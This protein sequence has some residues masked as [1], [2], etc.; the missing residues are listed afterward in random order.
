MSFV[1]VF[2]GED[3][4]S[5]DPFGAFHRFTAGIRDRCD[6]PPATTVLHP[7]GAYRL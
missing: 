7:I 4:Q 5:L 1:H 2:Q 6:E 3:G